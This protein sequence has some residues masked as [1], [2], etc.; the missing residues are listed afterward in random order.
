MRVGLEFQKREPT[1]KWKRVENIDSD[2]H[3]DKFYIP[4]GFTFKK[5]EF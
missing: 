5:M 2:K 1:S 4:F 3:E